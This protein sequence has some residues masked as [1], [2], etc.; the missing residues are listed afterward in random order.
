MHCVHD[1]IECAFS[2]T[3]LPRIFCLLYEEP[4]YA[5]TAAT[6]LNQGVGNLPMTTNWRTC[7]HHRVGGSWVGDYSKPITPGKLQKLLSKSSPN[8]SENAQECECYSCTHTQKE[9]RERERERE[10]QRYRVCICVCVCVCVCVCMGQFVP[11]L[12]SIPKCQ[13]PPYMYVYMCR[14]YVCVLLYTVLHHPRRSQHQ[15]L[16]PSSTMRDS[17]NYPEYTALL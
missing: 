4:H 11:R 17:T 2:T 10:K 14:L 16:P 6:N 15:T 13:C 3:L 9:K 7:Q 5:S 8:V 1:T 12:P